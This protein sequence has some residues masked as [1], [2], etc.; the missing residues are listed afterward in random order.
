VLDSDVDAL[1]HVAVANLLLEDDTDGGLGDVVDDT[2]LSVVDLVGHTLL[3]GTCASVSG[4]PC[5]SSF[6]CSGGVCTVGYDIDDITDLVLLEVGG[7]RDL[8]EYSYQL[9]LLRRG[10]WRFLTIP[11]FLKSLEKLHTVSC[12]RTQNSGRNTHA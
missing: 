2:G 3:D 9:C 10:V 4:L 11:R 8:C 12:R 1:L 7:E 6:S 5:A